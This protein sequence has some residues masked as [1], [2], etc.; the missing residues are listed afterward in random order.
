MAKG[1]SKIDGNTEFHCRFDLN[2]EF[3][4][5]I[6]TGIHGLHR[7][8]R[9]TVRRDEG[10]K[11]GD[12]SADFDQYD[13]SVSPTGLTPEWTKVRGYN[14]LYFKSEDDS[15]FE[16]RIGGD[17]HSKT[18]DFNSLCRNS[19]NLTNPSGGLYLQPGYPSDISSNQF[20]LTATSHSAA[21]MTFCGTNNPNSPRSI[22]VEP[23]IK[24]KYGDKTGPS[25]HKRI[26]GTKGLIP[27]SVD[28]ETVIVR[29]ANGYVHVLRE[30][31][32]DEL[33]IQHT[34]ALWYSVNG[35]MFVKCED[36]PLGVGITAG[37]FSKANEMFA[38]RARTF[39]RSGGTN[40]FTAV[41][42]VEYVCGGHEL[43][44]HYMFDSFIRPSYDESDVVT[45]P[46]VHKVNNKKTCY[47]V[48]YFEV[49]SELP[50]INNM[51]N[52]LGEMFHPESQKTDAIT[53]HEV[54]ELR[55]FEMRVGGG[56]HVTPKNLYDTVYKNVTS[57]RNWYH[58]WTCLG[59]K[60][61][62]YI[63]NQ[64][65]LQ[66]MIDHMADEK[67]MV[68]IKFGN[69]LMNGLTKNNEYDKAQSLV[70]AKLGHATTKAAFDR[71]LIGLRHDYMKNTGYSVQSEDDLSAMASIESK[72]G[73]RA[74]RDLIITG[75]QTYFKKGA[76]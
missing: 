71:A 68:V 44:A 28:G 4:P 32:T 57:G 75:S 55:K 67:E 52:T 8:L 3:N 76:E 56:T 2:V 38:R 73:Y 63:R 31:S 25:K 60:L 42:H 41:G 61:I 11:S 53:G 5:A 39:A 37:S 27:C 65:T 70:Y 21:M 19:F 29:H 64:D 49:G 69:K 74:V 72:S 35:H 48:M 16:I 18:E 1:L 66:R 34:I 51:W 15:S 14:E 47:N 24:L 30:G 10:H 6:L 43:A 7:V 54:Y 26:S 58:G 22:K 33:S 9:W 13:L 17:V 46:V 36:G 20:G 59:E 45:V 50:S 12:Q 23:E 40:K 62:G